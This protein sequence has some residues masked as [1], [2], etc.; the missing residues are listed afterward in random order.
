MEI[1]VKAVQPVKPLILVTELPMV[2]LVRFLQPENA[3]LPI[4]I[5]ELGMIMLVRPVQP[6]YSQLVVYQLIYNKTVE[7]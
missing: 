6:T 5:T 1:L 4:R 7:K 2:T 3:E